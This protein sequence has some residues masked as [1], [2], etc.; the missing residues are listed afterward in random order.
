MD[1]FRELS[2]FVAVVEEGSLAGAA[3]RLNMSPPAVT[4]KVNA[5]E[6]RLDIRLFNRTTRRIALTEAGSQFHLDATRILS[7]LEE[8]EA[9]AAGAHDAPRG[10]L[11]VTAPVQFGQ[12]FIAPILRDF[13]DTYPK[14]RANAL[15]LDRVVNIIDEGLDIAL[16]IAELPDSSLTAVRV[17]AVRRVTVAAPS[18]VETH[19]APA[20]LADLADLRCINPRQLH[21]A[22]E[23]HYSVAGEITPARITPT[24]EV[25]TVTASIEA[26]EAGWG[27]TRALSYQVADALRDGRLV[28]VLT[29]FED[30]E[31][32]V[33]LVHAEG[34]RAA[35]KIRAFIDFAAKRL[36]QQ[37]RVLAAR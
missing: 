6:E 17:G 31:V 34:R 4:R 35:A 16:R 13:L 33:H 9:W 12:R 11:R 23:W 30:R 8:A 15:F 5:L 24:L 20:T 10:V 27:I 25:N 28:E 29:E 36:R 2:T 18:F 14:V 1:R 32:P 7:E 22:H 26:A 19:G 3:R 21:S 37:S